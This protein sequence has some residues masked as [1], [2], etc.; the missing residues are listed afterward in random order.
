MGGRG[1]VNTPPA[2]PA[3]PSSTRT[4]VAP[5]TWVLVGLHGCS[6]CADPAGRANPRFT[7]ACQGSTRLPWHPDHL[8]RADAGRGALSSLLELSDA[9]IVATTANAAKGGLVRSY[10]SYDA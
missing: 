7:P 4:R 1:A 5:T 2:L 9:A 3:V 10:V 8:T 6:E